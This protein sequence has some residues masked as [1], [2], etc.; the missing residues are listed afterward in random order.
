MKNSNRYTVVRF[1]TVIFFLIQIVS[2]IASQFTTGKH[3]CW[4]P[5][6]TQN[7]YTISCVVNGV[8]LTG[9]EI[10][11]R[12]GIPANGWEAHQMQNVKDFIKEHERQTGYVDT[13][14]VFIQYTENGGTTKT[15]AYP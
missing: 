3:F 6:N 4:A 5:H 15:W 12:Y 2:V 14:I 1:I 9:K 13:T 10:Q 8:S 7:F 11:L